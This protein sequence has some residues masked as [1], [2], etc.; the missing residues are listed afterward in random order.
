MFTKD[1]LF[2]YKNSNNVKYY[3]LPNHLNVTY[4]CNAKAEFPAA[5]IISIN[6][7]EFN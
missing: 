5:I 6:S 1:Y 3:N 4:S 2:D 7:I